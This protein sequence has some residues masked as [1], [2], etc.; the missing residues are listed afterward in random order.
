MEPSIQLFTLVNLT[1]GHE[2]FTSYNAFLKTYVYTYLQH[3]I[4]KLQNYLLQHE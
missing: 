3:K 2:K 1:F 4:I